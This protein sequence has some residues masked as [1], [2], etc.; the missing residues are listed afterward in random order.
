MQPDRDA[1]RWAER[2]Q[3]FVRDEV[4]GTQ[5]SIEARARF[6]SAF[7]ADAAAARIVSIY[8]EAFERAK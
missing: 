3:A 7:T 2:I 5:L 4:A 1:A 6:L 8:R